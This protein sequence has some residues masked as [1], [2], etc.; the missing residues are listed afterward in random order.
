M[1]SVRRPTAGATNQV[2][3]ETKQ[4]WQ[5]VLLLYVLLS[6]IVRLIPTI[7][8]WYFVMGIH[9]YNNSSTSIR[10]QYIHEIAHREFR[11]QHFRH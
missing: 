9:Y 6:Y 3:W 4:V 7:N 2:L 10:Q 5:N 11:L 1:H 8:T